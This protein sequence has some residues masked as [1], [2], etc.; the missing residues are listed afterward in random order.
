M[1]NFNR[2]GVSDDFLARAGCHH[3]GGDECV[4]LYGCRAEGIAIAFHTL[5]GEPSTDNGKPFARV[6]LY[7]ATETQKYHQR[8]G[9]GTHI[10]I[11]HD[12]PR[13]ATLILT[14]GEFKAASLSEAGFCAL[15]LCGIS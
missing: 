9:S 5:T 7:D 1:S 6:R 8:S 13:G 4:Q 3:V 14:E 10:Y 11:P 12:L 15:G 2:P